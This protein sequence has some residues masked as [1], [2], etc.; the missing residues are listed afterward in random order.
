MSDKATPA[1]K[2][3]ILRLIMVV[4]LMFGFGYAMVPLYDLLCDIT[5]LNGKTGVT[6][7]QAVNEHGVDQSRMVTV[8]F[9]GNTAGGLPWDFRP[10]VNS[11]K[12]HPGEVTHATYI[13]RNRSNRPIIGQA[14]P[15]VSPG[16]ASQHFNKTECFCF[17]QQRLEAGE[18]K[19]MPITFVVERGLPHDIVRMTLSYAFFE[20]KDA[21]AEEHAHA[22]D[23]ENS[24]AKI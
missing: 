5:G 16:K 11:M 8:E 2:R 22:A 21:P 10:T 4:V 20:S 9:T 13:A 15:S 3:I 17:T 24:A 12:V 23:T 1:N 18:E 6:T 14:I 19:E 7:T